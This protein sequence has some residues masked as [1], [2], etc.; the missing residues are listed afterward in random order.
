M[1]TMLWI[2]QT[3]QYVT[4]STDFTHYNCSEIRVTK[5]MSREILRLQMF[6]IMIVTTLY[7]YLD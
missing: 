5:E 1:K 4:A 7:P 3:M 2:N 6:G